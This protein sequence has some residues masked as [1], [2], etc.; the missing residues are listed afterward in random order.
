MNI[1]LDRLFNPPLK[2]LSDG[3]SIVHYI[4]Q[5]KGNSSGVLAIV[6]QTLQV[7]IQ[8]S[9]KEIFDE[10]TWIERLPDQFIK[11]SAPH[12]SPEEIDREAKLSLEERIQLQEEGKCSVRMFMNSFRPELELKKWTWWDAEILDENHIAVAVEVEDFLFPWQGL[13]WLFKGA[14][15]LEPKYP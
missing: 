1:E 10:R 11:N 2:G 5:C 12:P 7:A 15:E 13:R 8:L 4:A 14:I 3:I 6:K 9:D